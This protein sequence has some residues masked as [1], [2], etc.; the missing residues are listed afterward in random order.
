MTAYIGDMSVRGKD[1]MIRKQD[2]SNPSKPTNNKK[3]KK[4]KR[5]SGY[6]LHI[7]HIALKYEPL[8]LSDWLM[9]DKVIGALLNLSI[10]VIG[11]K[12][13]GRSYVPSWVIGAASMYKDGYADMTLEEFIKRINPHS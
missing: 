11:C 8:I 6:E 10:R 2:G 7:E 5:K 12:Q 1:I 4:F 9:Y 3:R 13:C